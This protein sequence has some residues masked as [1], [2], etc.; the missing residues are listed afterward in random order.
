MNT[1][2]DIKIIDI[3]KIK[4]MN[5][6]S[7]NKSIHDGIKD[8]ID[9]RGLSK[10]ISVREI[11]DLEYDYSLICGQGRIEALVKLGETTIP[12]II[13]NV[14]EEE[15]YIMSLVENIARRKP[16]SNE[17]LE[18]IRSMKLKGLSDSEIG[19]ITG[20]STKWIRS[21]NMLLNKGEHRLL[22]CVE[23][24]TIP[25]YLAVDFA[26]R[27]SEEAQILLT[28]AYEKKLI[29]SR[30][31]LK[32]KNILSQRVEGSKGAKTAGYF[33]KKQV[34]SISPEELVAIYKNNISEHKIIYN[35]SELVKT[36]LTIIREIIDSLLKIDT[37]VRMLEQEGLS[38]LPT[39]IISTMENKGDAK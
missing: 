14:S 3:S 5:P 33:Y 16:R 19:E 23:N 27:T 1:D 11:D 28:E 37:F 26:S 9:R 38:G 7:R 10:P 29:R 15:A 4:I 36:N 2:Y 8:S 21:I 31:V 22:S 13:R 39:C 12:A 6:R 18:V 30:D 32:I 17:L 20:Y 34:K 24:G 35:Q 25:L